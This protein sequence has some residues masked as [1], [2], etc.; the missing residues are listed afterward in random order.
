MFRDCDVP[1]LFASSV[2]HRVLY[3]HHNF[4]SIMK[5]YIDNLPVSLDPMDLISA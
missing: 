5:F 3:C 1:R 4:I 2:Y